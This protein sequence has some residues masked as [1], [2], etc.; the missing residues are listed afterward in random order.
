MPR[1]RESRL[2]TLG[3]AEMAPTAHDRAHPLV[4]EQLHKDNR[5]F[6]P[7]KKDICRR[8]ICFFAAGD[9]RCIVLQYSLLPAEHAEPVTV[10][11]PGSGNGS[12]TN[13][14]A[15]R[16]RITLFY[17]VTYFFSTGVAR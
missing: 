17:S 2:A 7:A 11:H 10:T 13:L 12:V 1:E 14:A 4:L 8:R 3:R 15:R 5:C 6:Y 9:E 16:W